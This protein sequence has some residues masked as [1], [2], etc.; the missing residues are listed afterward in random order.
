MGRAQDPAPGTRPL[1]CVSAGAGRPLVLLHGY[2]MQPW[3]YLGLA[4]ALGKEAR[5]VIPAIFALRGRWTFARALDALVA[6]LDDLGLDRVSLLGHSFGG[7]LE[8]GLAAR[9]PDRVVECVF[10]DTLGVKERFGLA[11]EALRHPLGILAMAT[12]GAAASFLQSLA[13]HPGQLAAAA[14]WGFLSEREPDIEAV[15]QAGIPC[16]VM[17][18]NHDTLLARSD[19]EEFA[20]RLHAGFTVAAGPPVEHDWMFENPELFAAHLR[21]LGLEVLGG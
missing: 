8:L 2:A 16:H 15:V 10:A 14:V 3:T 20:R 13:T 4:R 11:G 17:W 19:G 21:R 18:A 12:P 6:T 9:H 7:G 1:G 5:V